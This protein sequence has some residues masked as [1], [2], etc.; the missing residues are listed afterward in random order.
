MASE[1]GTDD[2]FQAPGFKMVRR[3]R[4]LELRT[5]RSPAEQQELKRRMWGARPKI[6]A[7]IQKRNNTTDLIHKYTS[8][9]LVANLFLRD[10]M[11]NPNEYKESESGLRPHWVEH[12]AVLELKDKQYELRLSPLFD[13][14]D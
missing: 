5:H 13:G 14:E 10:G 1:K 8:F 7:E 4:H 2:V 11:Q 9:D 3:C 6:L 12:A